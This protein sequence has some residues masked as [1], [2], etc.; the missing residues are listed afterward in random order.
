MKLVLASQSPRRKEL[1]KILGYPFSVMP[2]SI[3]SGPAW[4]V[5][6]RAYTAKPLFQE[7]RRPGATGAIFTI[8]RDSQPGNGLCAEAGP[9][10]VI[11]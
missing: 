10:R 2:A 8:L 5:V 11:A 4:N 6:D 7:V 3:D 1:L 9:K